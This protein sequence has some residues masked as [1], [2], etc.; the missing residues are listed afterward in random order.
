MSR[1]ITISYQRML[2]NQ[3]KM[4]FPLLVFLMLVS[5]FSTKI[6][7]AE[8]IKALKCEVSS[9]GKGSTLLA[10]IDGKST[11]WVDFTEW[12]SEIAKDAPQWIIVSFQHADTVRAMDIYSGNREKD[13]I[14]NFCVQIPDG[15]NWKTLPDARF[16]MNSC[17]H[18]RITFATPVSSDK[19][20][21][22]ID[23]GGKSYQSIIREWT[24]WK[25]GNDV[26]PRVLVIPPWRESETHRYPVDRKRNLVFLNQSGFNTDWPKR[27]TAPLTADGARFSITSQKDS[28]KV[29]FKGVVK[30][31]IGDF[32]IFKPQN[33][34]D[35]YVIKVESDSLKPGFSDPFY[36]APFWMQRV[37]QEPMLRFFVDDRSIVGTVFGGNCVHPWRDSPCYAYS[38]QSLIHLL[39]ANPSFYLQQPVEMDWK[40]DLDKV[41]DQPHDFLQSL[42]WGFDY[43]PIVLAQKIRKEVPAPIG[44]NVPDIIQLI[45][46]GTA[47]DL[48]QPAQNDHSNLK[49]GIYPETIS[50]FAFFLYALPY[51]KPYISKEFS[52]RVAKYAF[53]QWEPIGLLKLDKRL[54]HFKGFTAVGW[55][56]LPNL[57]M[58]EVAKGMNRNDASRYLD[59]A[60]AQAK[61]VVDSVDFKNP[62]VT[63]GV[64]MS[65]HKTMNGLVTL[66]RNYPDKAPKGLVEKLT[67]WTDIIISR[68]DN[69]WDYRKFDN[70]A[71]WSLP[72]VM[73]GQEGGGASWND[74]G[75]LAGFPSCA[76]KIESILGNSKEDII[77]KKRLHELAVAQWDILF[78]R[79]P[80][81]AHSGYRGKT[82]FIG[83]ERG[84]PVS[85]YPVCGYL[86]TV[87]GTLSSSPATEHF[88]FNPEGEFR[89]PEGWTAFN[90]AFN[91]S[92]AESIHRETTISYKN[93]KITV[94]G[95]F[96]VPN[97]NIDIIDDKGITTTLKLTAENSNQDS[98]SIKYSINGKFSVRYGFGYFATFRKFNN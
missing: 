97:I 85:F 19:F 71:N 66:L 4:F 62:I 12:R 60:V 86:E 57:M 21:L 68:S 46:W 20:R 50:E 11:T 51:M 13:A 90:A 84:W 55:T 33:T 88:P 63:K 37:T 2:Q 40:N 53:E 5:V 16:F 29:L 93:S 34:S 3:N 56:I 61:W 98:Y 28:T 81:G 17:K 27:F 41:M 83:V 43:D 22:W 79:N 65:E 18:L 8:K 54:G 72:R 49:F 80:L 87:R 69:L 14:M 42:D 96:F 26:L 78:G 73:P 9:E 44:K 89:H 82:D 6:Y 92:L 75:N 30:N 59:A 70:G 35:Q 45:Q 15:E 77:R 64:R 94:Q 36:I 76:W 52:D 39:L 47:W 7:A 58:Y 91:V 95:P 1:N 10:P 74:P 23:D 25:D 38:V 67:E 32:S 48:T 24:F 31:K